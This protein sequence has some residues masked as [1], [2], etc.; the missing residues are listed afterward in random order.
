MG[1]YLNP[2]NQSF[3]EIRNDN[4][5]DK[6]GMI[7]LINQ[8]INKNSRLTCISRPRRFGKS[9]AAEMLLAYYD[10]S[11]DSHEIFD[12]LE[13]ALTD[14]YETFINSFDVIYID[15]ANI[16]G[17]VREDEIVGYIQRNIVNELVCAY[18]KLQVCEAFDE[19]LVNVVELTGNKFIMII[20]EW[21]VIIRELPDQTDDYLK[22]LRTM[23]KS[24]VTTNRIFAAVYMTGILPI[25]K[26]GTGSALS[27]FKEY[28]MLKPWKY[29]KYVGF[30]A[31]E[32]KKLCEDQNG[33]YELMKEWYDGYSFEKDYSIYNPN[34][35]MEALNTGDYISYWTETSIADELM[36]YISKGYNDLTKTIAELIAGIEVTVNTNGF[37]ND[38]V[39]FKGKDDV[40]TLL[41]HLGYLAYDR[42]AGTVRIPN[43]EI[44]QEFI[45]AVR[46]VDHMETKKRVQ[47]S[48]QLIENTIMM[49]EEAVATQLAKV[50]MEETSPIHYNRE[51]DLRS[52]IKLA[53]YTYRDYYL[54]WE[55]LP[56]GEGYA[57]VVYLPKKNSDYPI[58]IIELK[59]NDKV[60]GAIA[61][62]KNKKYTDKLKDYGNDILLVGVN[63]SKDTKEHTCIIEKL[64]KV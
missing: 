38:L 29:G 9:F 54:Q 3:K 25:K 59:W 40:L 51:K 19:T 43:E 33:D 36:D 16:A 41:I 60:E 1:K 39:T 57:D 21:D 26:T 23:F 45:K 32:V 7:E 11:C 12:D 8:S 53:Y 28:S 18:P 48:D 55:E 2:G 15:M 35:V 17:K 61:Q 34:S 56:T 49:R 24:S 52:V 27:N 37:A 31:E 14:D 22:F 46:E 47:E 13:I 63:Y 30:T 42:Q 50:H 4:Y 44:K 20:D 64:E 5:V 62:I 58:L 6:T 10:K